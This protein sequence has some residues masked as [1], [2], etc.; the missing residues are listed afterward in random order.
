M[1]TFTAYVEYDSDTGLFVGTIPGVS[2]AH[3]QGET[4][5][6]LR[7]KLQEVLE[8]VLA[9]LDEPIDDLPEFVGTLQASIAWRRLK[10]DGDQRANT[11][12]DSLVR[13]RSGGAGFV[14]EVIE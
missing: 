2:G 7:A 10:H 5:E 9:E 6:E 4:I 12:P 14:F 1:R 13:P 8:L 3:T 11:I